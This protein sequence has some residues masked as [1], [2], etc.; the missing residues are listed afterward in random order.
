MSSSCIADM[1]GHSIS[2]KIECALTP[3]CASMQS[4][5]SLTGTLCLANDLKRPQAENTDHHA[6]IDPSLLGAHAV[7]REMLCPGSIK[8]YLLLFH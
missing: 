5:Q 1:H 7:L 3:A 8:T 6:Q 2:Y 4:D